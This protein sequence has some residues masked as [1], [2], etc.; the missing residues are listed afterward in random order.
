M[1]DLRILVVNQ[2]NI[3]LSIIFKFLLPVC[4]REKWSF[5]I[6][7]FNDFRKLVESYFL[8]VC[9]REKLEIVQSWTQWRQLTFRFIHNR[10]VKVENKGSI[11]FYFRPVFICCSAL[12]CQ[13]LRDSLDCMYDARIP[14]HWKKV[15]RQTGKGKLQLLERCNVVVGEV[16]HNF[17]LQQ[18]YNNFKTE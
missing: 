2:N 8:V 11:S 7:D 10:L 4:A 12:F 3:S 15:F 14:T 6:L 1:P 13:T 18:F 16:A 9:A 5:S 17:K